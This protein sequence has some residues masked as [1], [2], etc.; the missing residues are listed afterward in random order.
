M[1][2][3]MVQLVLFY[4]YRQTLV[5]NSLIKG[6]DGFGTMVWN[7]SLYV[8]AAVIFPFKRVHTP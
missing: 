6:V 8:F 3:F 1:L 5:T 7:D 2:N 4:I